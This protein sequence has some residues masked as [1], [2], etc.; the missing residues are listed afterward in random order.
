MKRYV[1]HCHYV[2]FMPSERLRL[3]HTLNCASAP[4]FRS[5]LTENPAFVRAATPWGDSATL[6]SFSKL[7][8]G[9]PEQLWPMIATQVL[10]RILHDQ[11]GAGHTDGKLL[12]GDRLC[13]EMAYHRFSRP[14]KRMKDIRAKYVCMRQ[15]RVVNTSDQHSARRP[16]NSSIYKSLIRHFHI[17]NMI[18]KF[19]MQCAI[20]WF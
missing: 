14:R 16:A 2:Y 3:R 9:T 5:T 12:I 19:P 6:L 15:T 8:R 1:T 17:K 11:Q 10:A 18:Y 7:S 13:C 4:A 20:C